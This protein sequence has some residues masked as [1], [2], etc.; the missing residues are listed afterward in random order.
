M[1]RKLK[2]TLDVMEDE[3]LREGIRRLVADQLKSVTRQEAWSL[4][5]LGIE[6][7]TITKIT[8]VAEKA[9]E[10]Q[11]QAIMKEPEVR[12]EMIKRI[13]DIVDGVANKETHD[14]VEKYGRDKIV[15]DIQHEALKLAAKSFSGAVDREVAKERAK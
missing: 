10:K 15:R 2:L 3:A 13:Y 6:T 12:G 11:I 1:G 4:V 9:I 14:I 7:D 8:A 5:K